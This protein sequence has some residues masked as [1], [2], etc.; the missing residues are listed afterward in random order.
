M[1]DNNRKFLFIHVPKTGGQS[2][3]RSVLKSYNLTWD[4]KD[5]FLMGKNPD[6]I[7]QKTSHH[8]SHLRASE[9]LKYNHISEQQFNEYFKFSFVR[10]PWRRVVSFYYYLDYNTR[11][12]FDRFVMT[13]LEPTRNLR[14]IPFLKPQHDYLYIDD[15]LSV[16]YLGRT[17][18]MA[19]DF[20]NIKNKIGLGHLKQIP[21]LNTST[22]DNKDWKN[23]YNQRLIKKVHSLYEKDI[24]SFKYTF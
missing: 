4:D 5:Q 22:P 12:E 8:F 21:K 13:Q 16:D 11:M 17:E 6:Y 10:N 9:F 19:Q 1:L 3:E 15:N 7:Q 24:D 20:Q 23:L 2:I 18:T 14:L